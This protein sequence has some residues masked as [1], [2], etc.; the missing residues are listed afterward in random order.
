[1]LGGLTAA[2]ASLAP[3]FARAAG[4]PIVYGVSGPF[5]GDRA[6]YGAGWK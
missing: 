1:V 4:E 6:A 3:R 5:S 2:A